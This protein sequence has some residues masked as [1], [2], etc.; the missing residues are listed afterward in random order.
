MKLTISIKYA[1]NIYY[2]ILKYSDK[3]NNGKKEVTNYIYK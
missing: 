3:T 2:S 1:I